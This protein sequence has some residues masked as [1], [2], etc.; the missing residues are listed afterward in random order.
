MPS[1]TGSCAI[2]LHRQPA[3]GLAAAWAAE[4]DSGEQVT[5][6]S[7]ATQQRKASLS[8]AAPL[9]VQGDLPAAWLV[10]CPRDLWA[11]VQQR[12]RFDRVL[13]FMELRLHEMGAT[14][15]LRLSVG[16]EQAERLQRALFAIADQAG[17]DREMPEVSAACTTSSAA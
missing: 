5:E 15:D 16:D 6:L 10:N 13:Q 3:F 9:R 7:A 2:H 14:E 1:F 12:A 8:V 4:L 17:A 11:D